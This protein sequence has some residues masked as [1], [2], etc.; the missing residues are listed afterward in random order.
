MAQKR[1]KILPLY[2]I[3]LPN[4][5]FSTVKNIPGKKLDTGI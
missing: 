3:T 4:P 1:V 5:I 2:L